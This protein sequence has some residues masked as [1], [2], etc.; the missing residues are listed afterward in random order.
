MVYADSAAAFYLDIGFYVAAFLGLCLGSLATALAYRLPR[1]ISMVAR[2]RS[3]CPACGRVLSA[4]DLVPVFSWVY[5]RG[6]CRGC[7]AAYG[8]RYLAIELATVSLCL[9]FYFLLPPGSAALA[10]YAVAAILVAHAAIDFEWQIL[11]DK[12]NLA[13]GAAGLYAILHL[14]G[15]VPFATAP[16]DIAGGAVLFAF[17][18]AGAALYAGVALGL[19]AVMQWRMGREPMGLGDVK[20]FAAAGFFLGP[21]PMRFGLFMLAAGAGGLVLGLIWQKAM[22]SDEFPFGP[23]LIAAFTGFLLAGEALLLPDGLQYVNAF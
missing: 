14:A 1:D 9:A 22:K 12:L 8:R 4:G 20:F 3:Q 10:F 18:G 21:D 17:A 2:R 19:R 16:L 13:L 5:L 7:K 15:V 6:R 11:P 23:A